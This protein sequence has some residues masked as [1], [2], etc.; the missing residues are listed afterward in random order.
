M[1]TSVTAGRLL[2]AQY[3]QD[4]LAHI[5]IDKSG[6]ATEPESFIAMDGLISTKKQLVMPGDLKE[7]TSPSFFV[8]EEIVIALDYTRQIFE[9]REN[10][11]CGK[12]VERFS[13]SMIMLYRCCLLSSRARRGGS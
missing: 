13:I 10:K 12:L 4:H 6:Q 7:E 2:S 1:T 8:V 3:P 11:V 9:M 5:F